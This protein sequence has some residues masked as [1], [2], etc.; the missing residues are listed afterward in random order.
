MKNV[1][2]SLLVAGISI[3]WQQVY[4]QH[5]IRIGFG[6]CISQDN[7]QKI[8]Y[9]VND[10]HPD[11]FLFLGDN[12]YGDTQ[13]MAVLKAKYGQLG[14]KPGL[15]KL[16]EKTKV[17]A[18][19]DDHDYGVNDGGKE[20]PKK[21]ESKEIFLDFFKEP[22]ES[23]R[24]KHPGIYHQLVVGPE[25]ERVQFILLDCR[26]FR[27]KLCRVGKD[28]DC[29]GEY[30]KCEDS[31][32]TMLGEEQWKWLEE[33]LKVPAD[34]RIVCS[35]TQFLVDF[36]GWEAWANFPYERERMMRLIE[37]TKANGLFFV[38]GDVHY[39]EM[40]KLKRTNAYPF[41]DLT[42][43]GMTHGH[44][45]AGENI[46]RIHGAY[47]KPNFGWI[48]IEWKGMETLITLK[49]ISEEGEVKIEHPIYLKEL[50]F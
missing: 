10:L 28:E 35:S 11:Y 24:R 19:W 36:N 12:I 27:D 37:K 39:S 21:E 2:A 4:S 13:N 5:K 25:G 49:I 31:T 3:G 20:Y 22:A 8:W 15:Q 40:S 32:K 18:V 45:C 47:M 17:L 38:S 48:D 33:T 29:Y 23:E 1:I 9:K 6:S 16:W 30:G 42:S 46:H 50:Q 7:E 34:I 43:S 14:S 41:Y 26:T 44:S